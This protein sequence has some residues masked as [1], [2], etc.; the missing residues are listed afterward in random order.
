MGVDTTV[1]G[2]LTTDTVLN[3]EMTTPDGV[4]LLDGDRCLVTNQTDPLY[5]GV[6]YV[7]TTAWTFDEEFHLYPAVAVRIFAG[8]EYKHSEWI[9]NAE[10]DVVPGVGVQNWVLDRLRGVGIPGNGLTRDATTGNMEIETTGITPGTYQNPNITVNDEGRIQ[11]ATSAN[12]IRTYI[13]GLELQYVSTTQIRILVGSAY[14]PGLNRIVELNTQVNLSPILSA[15][16]WYYVYLYDVNGVGQ[17]EVSTMWYDAPYLGNAR[18][19]SGDTTRRFIGEFGTNVSAQIDSTNFYSHNLAS[20]A[21]PGEIELAT[22]NE[23]HAGLDATRAISP[24]TLAAK[25]LVPVGTIVMYGANRATNPPGRW[26]RCLGQSALRA[27]FPELFAVIGT[28]YGEG[29]NPGTTFAYPDLTARFP[30]GAS[31][32]RDSGSV[33]GAETHTLTITEMPA[34]NHTYNRAGGQQNDIAPSGGRSLAD[35]TAGTTGSRGGDAAH[36][37]MPPYQTIMFIIRSLP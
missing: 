14:I 21:F 8:N 12:I 2:V 36:N 17:I 6:Y 28:M 22:L 16:S 18:H 31:V 3:G 30:L 24:Y 37:N 32:A 19:K 13:E 35:T 20:T 4:S 23:I 29:S 33:G 7:H 15:S 5:N 34:H 27:D 9:L 26:Q 1:K 10:A 11:S 25:Q